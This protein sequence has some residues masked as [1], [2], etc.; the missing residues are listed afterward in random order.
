VVKPTRDSTKTG[1]AKSMTLSLK[2]NFKQ[3]DWLAFR[4]QIG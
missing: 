1:L 2:L 3:N 4:S